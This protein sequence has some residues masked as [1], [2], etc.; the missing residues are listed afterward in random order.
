METYVENLAPTDNTVPELRALDES[1]HISAKVDVGYSVKVCDDIFSYNNLDIFSNDE[2]SR[3]VAQ[4]VVIDANVD[5]L[6]GDRIR[7][8]F[9]ENNIQAV[10]FS[11]EVS[12]DL[13][14]LDGALQIVDKL[15]YQG[16]LRRSNPF[17]AIGGGVLLDMAGFAAS[18]YRRGVPYIR[19]PTNLMG[20]IDASLG[21]KTAVNYAGRRNRLG[22]YH[23]P[24][25]AILDRRF[26]TTVGARDISNG[27][28]EVLK[29]AVIKDKRLFN[30]IESHGNLLSEQ[31]L[32]DDICAQ[33]VIY[34]S[35]HGMLEELAPNLWELELERCVD[36]GHSFSPLVE[37]RALPELLHGE[38]VAL[39]VV[40]SCHIAAGRDLISPD[41]L[42][43]IL[44]TTRS[45]GLSTWHPSFEDLETVWESLAD[46]TRH[47]DGKQ[48]LPLPVGIG[49]HCFVNDV[50]Q[51]EVK[52]AI[53]D[54]K[55]TGSVND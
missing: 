25:V 33:E 13:K 24:A 22:T 23:P 16:V 37:M 29:L 15:E 52:Q 32:Q 31:K 14:L 30:L 17:I 2:L 8:F 28:G 38:A 39:D 4:L 10:F 9:E 40:L 43:Q 27:L 54:M 19:I 35:V 21:V 48:R 50:T 47:R 36:F 41:E 3:D 44:G 11:L 49:S 20:L 51:Q 34:R 12:E 18:L 26:L 6:H 5:R 1:W 55:R 45:L 42:N 46:A 7:A 53:A